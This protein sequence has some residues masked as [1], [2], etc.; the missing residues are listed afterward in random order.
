MPAPWRRRF[1]KIALALYLL[2]MGFM[3]GVAYERMRFDADRKAVLDRYNEMVRKVRAH[4]M[5]LERPVQ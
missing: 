4:Q 1:L 5:D 3:V 2:A